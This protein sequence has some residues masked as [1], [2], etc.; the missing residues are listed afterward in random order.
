M[1]DLEHFKKIIDN[2]FKID[3]SEQ[4]RKRNYFFARCIFFKLANELT[5]YSLEVLGRYVGNSGH[6]GAHYG[7]KVFNAEI[8]S[9]EKFKKDYHNILKSIS[10]N[11]DTNLKEDLEVLSQEDKQE[12]LKEPKEKIIDKFNKPQNKIITELSKLDDFTLNDFYFNR[13]IPYAKINNIQLND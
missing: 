7:L 3:I 8:N 9:N 6:C 13:F 12:P 2:Y 4:T 5:P 10:K 1:K 11:N